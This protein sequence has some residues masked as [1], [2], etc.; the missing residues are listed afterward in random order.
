MITNFH[1]IAE[2]DFRHQYA[3]YA[4]NGQ[5]ENGDDLVT[6]NIYGIGDTYI[7]EDTET[8]YCK[9]QNNG[10]ADDWSP[11]LD[12]LGG[13][14]EV[15]ECTCNELRGLRY[16]GNLKPG[17]YYR[18]TDYIADAGHAFDI[19]VLALTNTALSET[20]KA[21]QHEGDTYFNGQ[22]LEKW[23]LRYTLDS[24]TYGTITYMRDDKNN[25]AYYDFKNYL[26]VKTIN[27][28]Q[29][30]CYTFCGYGNDG[31]EDL[32]LNSYFQNNHI[33]YNS[34]ANVLFES[35]SYANKVG[36]NI[37]DN[38]SGNL[39]QSN[40]SDYNGSYCSIGNN[41]NGNTI[42][43]GSY[44][45]S[46]GNNS[47]GNTITSGSYNNKI[48]NF[49]SGVTISNGSY[50]NI[51][52]NYASSGSLIS[53]GSHDN[54]IGNYAHFTLYATSSYNVI[55][56]YA[57]L[58]C[59][60]M[61]AGGNNNRVGRM[62]NV[63]L[64]GTGANFNEIYDQCIG[65]KLSSGCQR[66]KI[67]S[68]YVELDGGCQ[69]NVIE[70]PC[71]MWG[72]CCSNKI[73]QGS[74]SYHEQGGNFLIELG[75]GA[76]GNVVGMRCYSTIYIK[77]YSNVVG[78]NCSSIS[79]GTT[80]DNGGGNGNIIG[81]YCSSV[82]IAAASGQWSNKNEIGLSASNITIGNNSE[83][84]KIGDR[85]SGITID[86]NSKS[87]VVGD[88]CSGITIDGNAK[89]N[90]VGDNCS[91]VHIYDYAES[92]KIGDKCSG[93][94][95]YSSHDQ[96]VTRESIGNKIGYGCSG[97][98]LGEN[99]EVDENEYT[100]I[101][102]SSNEIGSECNTILV[103]SNS[104]RNKIGDGCDTITIGSQGNDNRFG[105]GCSSI[106]LADGASENKFG[107]G[108][109]DITFQSGGQKNNSLGDGCYSIVLGG[110]EQHNSFGDGCYSITLRNGGSSNN[111]FGNACHDI[112]FQGSY[113]T[114]GDNC[115]N[116]ESNAVATPSI[117]NRNSLGVGCS[118]I[119]FNGDDNHFGNGVKYWEVYQNKCVW[120][121]NTIFD[122]SSASSKKYVYNQDG[123]TYCK[124][125][126]IVYK[127]YPSTL[128]PSQLS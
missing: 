77:G 113:N 100:L 6:N 109:H 25:S 30:S 118:D 39:I 63:T 16:N 43:A 106:T 12:Q 89:S 46:I 103:K 66:N 3:K 11:I 94:T 112:N 4:G 40:A 13:G 58:V 47:N 44:N 32:S 81:S 87:N 80:G 50:N 105:N 17:C 24:G 60:S 86:G 82:S 53:N 48:G 2:G 18:I 59:D 72:G 57:T 114:I 45:C 33:G 108:C 15:I 102:C 123:T 52:G 116:I 61:S 67:Y 115:S 21:V 68:S 79:I 125:G 54:Q 84:N 22:H 23:N 110:G 64:N 121:D 101:G 31:F 127:W 104:E 34:I 56:D 36:M 83:S 14:G 88:D 107:E 93:I 71:K 35:S 111:R 20:A 96:Y 28:E 74:D 119:I 7:D 75:S 1:I 91:T 128:T 92:N 51:V 85:C 95:I 122:G 70:S 55:E 10:N 69:D 9:T 42:S 73:K 38:S 27:D 120:Y 62:S 19:I 124:S 76:S 98:T 29:V 99:Y 126:S 26:F 117:I 49:N 41:S 78:D 65:V 8:L 97:I 5:P 37:G 90:V